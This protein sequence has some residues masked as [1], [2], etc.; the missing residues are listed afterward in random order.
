MCGHRVLQ[1]THPAHTIANSVLCIMQWRTEFTR[2]VEPNEFGV[3]FSKWRDRKIRR[4]SPRS[5]TAILFL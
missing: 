4:R 1:P 2:V 5:F 3:A